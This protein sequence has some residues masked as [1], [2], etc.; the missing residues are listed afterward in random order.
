MIQTRG[1]VDHNL[2]ED[3]DVCV[4]DD[5]GNKGTGHLVL[6]EKAFF[7]YYLITHM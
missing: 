3:I 2:D 6:A 5:D 4:D 1:D 7:R